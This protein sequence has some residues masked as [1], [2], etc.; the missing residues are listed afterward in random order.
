MPDTER[1]ATATRGK[2]LV[3]GIEGIV[4][5]LLLSIS[6][7]M[8]ELGRVIRPFFMHGPLQ[9]C[10]RLKRN[11]HLLQ[12]GDCAATDIQLSACTLLC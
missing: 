8:R 7:T 6:W 12:Y 4:A 10:V 9:E 2:I 5:A 11:W 3:V 1:K